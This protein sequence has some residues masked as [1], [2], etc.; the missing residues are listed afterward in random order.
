M[1]AMSSTFRLALPALL[2]IAL[3]SISGLCNEL[4]TPACHTFAWILVPIMAFT[5][6]LSPIS[7]LA[8][9]GLFAL[10]AQ[11][12]IAQFIVQHDLG[13]QFIGESILSPTTPAVAK[14]SAGSTALIRAY[15]P[16]QH[17]NVFGGVLLI[18]SMLSVFAAQPLWRRWILPTLILGLLLSFS[19][20]AYLGGTLFLLIFGWKY[21]RHWLPGFLLVFG[22]IPI[23]VMRFTDSGDQALAE[24]IRGYNWAITIIR[25]Q[26]ITH[27]VGLGAYA[28]T[29]ADYFRETNTPHNS[30]EVSPVHS[31]P[32]LLTAEFGL[33]LV[34]ALFI[35]FLMFLRKK[36]Y[37]F[38]IALIPPLLLDHYFLTNVSAFAL[39]GMMLFARMP[40]NE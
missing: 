11:W 31:V 1:T 12:G 37:I 8:L 22:L 28:G 18:A 36:R 39:L 23:M 34:I 6:R 15:G 19:R 27:G 32:L 14:F 29:L 9:T 5:L 26:P 16:Y 17:A 21:V 7:L 35:I 40:T 20:S 38:L 10:Q 30:W 33:L 25:A 2:L 13:F 4:V 3:P 24:R